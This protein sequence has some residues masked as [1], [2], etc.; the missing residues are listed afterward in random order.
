MSETYLIMSIAGYFHH[1]VKSVFICYIDILKF[2]WNSDNSSIQTIHEQNYMDS[3]MI[4]ST[5]PF[6]D[7]CLLFISAISPILKYTFFQASCF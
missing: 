3:T 1:D 4:S 2:P 6:E 7:Q 5:C